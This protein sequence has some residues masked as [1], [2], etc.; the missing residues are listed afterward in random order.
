LKKLVDA[1]FANRSAI[2]GSHHSIEGKSC[3]SHDV[4]AEPK[5]R[6]TTTAINN[7]FFI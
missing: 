3:K 5:V 1:V 7:N 4:S 2:H 6:M